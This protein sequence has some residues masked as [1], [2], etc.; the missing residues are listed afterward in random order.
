MTWPIEL[1]AFFLLSLK[2]GSLEQLKK[3]KKK[4]EGQRG[5][6]ISKMM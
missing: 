4:D 3:K 6:L 5:I 2:H 1:P